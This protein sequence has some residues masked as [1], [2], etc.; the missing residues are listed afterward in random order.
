M[1]DQVYPNFTMSIKTPLIKTCKRKNQSTR[2]IY[3]VLQEELDD[4]WTWY[5]YGQKSIKGLP[6]PRNYF[7][8]STSRSCEVKKLIEKSPK[9]ENYFL[10]SYSCECTMI[11]LHTVDLLLPATVV[12]NT[13]FQK[14]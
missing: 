5:K 13:N 6:F 12:P 4:K 14:A 8:C 9:N 11:C 7:K 10:V 3:E 1:Q 2:V